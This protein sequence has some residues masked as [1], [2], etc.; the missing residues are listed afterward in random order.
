MI[1]GMSKFIIKVN[2]IKKQ[3]HSHDI[4]LH[5]RT[6]LVLFCLIC[7]CFFVFVFVLFLVSRYSC[8]LKAHTHPYIFVPYKYSH[9][10]I[11]TLGSTWEELFK[12]PKWIFKRVCS[13]RFTCLI[14]LQWVCVNV[15]I[16][17]QNDINILFV[18]YKNLD[19]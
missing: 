14:S 19:D 6:T 7:L 15:H 8:S 1:R 3:I 11:K 10:E 9:V 4:K 18:R 16:N 2:K 17:K 13:S 5:L 12:R